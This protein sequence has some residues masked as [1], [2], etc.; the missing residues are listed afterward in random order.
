VVSCGG[1]DKARK[2]DK[3]ES[4]S[5]LPPCFQKFSPDSQVTIRFMSGAQDDDTVQ[6]MCCSGCISTVVYSI[7]VDD[8]RCITSRPTFVPQS[9]QSALNCYLI[10]SRSLQGMAISSIQY[11]P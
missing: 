7:C 3:A 11:P 2:E 5:F 4:C 10:D 6:A 9:H 1:E 8:S